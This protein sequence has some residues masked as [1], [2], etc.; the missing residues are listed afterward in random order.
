MGRTHREINNAYRIMMWKREGNLFGKLRHPC[1][2]LP[3]T[4]VPRRASTNAKSLAACEREW[5]YYLLYLIERSSFREAWVKTPAFDTVTWYRADLV[6][7]GKSVIQPS[8]WFRVH[9]RRATAKLRTEASSE[10]CPHSVIVIGCCVSA[11][12]KLYKKRN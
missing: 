11:K 6:S 9:T 2:N 3:L 12:V 1:V 5:N 8:K 4:N 7:I 10:G